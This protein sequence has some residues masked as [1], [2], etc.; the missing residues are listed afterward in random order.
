MEVWPGEGNL[1][2]D[3]LFVGDGDYR[4]RPESPAIDAGILDPEVIAD[5]ERLPRPCGSGVDMGAYESCWDCNRNGV[6]DTDDV[7][8][9]TSRDCNRNR[10]PDECDL[11]SKASSDCD[12][13]GIPD[14]CDIASG[15]SE[16]ENSNSILDGCEGRQRPGDVNQDG[17]LDLSDALWLLD[18][19]F[20]G[21]EPKLPCE[22]GS[23]SEPGAG[24]LALA[25]SSGDG[26]I[27][28]SD[29]VRVLGFLFLGA[30][31]PALGT[32]CVRIMGCP[33]TCR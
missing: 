29:V 28:L 1:N 27:D 23:A 6:A 3:P 22:G 12:G 20:L 21:I 7:A 18:H 4:L 8:A 10:V 13:N 24:D 26:R 16:D 17:S 15:T 14:E 30:E 5:I 19:L 25:D 32:E 2:A 33:E 11:A 31:P 9:G